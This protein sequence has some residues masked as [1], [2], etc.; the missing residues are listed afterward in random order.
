WHLRNDD[1]FILR[2]GDP[3]FVRETV[4]NMGGPDTAGFVEGSELDIPGVDRIHT[5]AAA[6]HLDWQYKFQKHWFRFMLWGRLGANPDEPESAWREE[7]TR[8]FG[9]AGPDAYEAIHQASKIL[10]LVTSY[11]WNY[12]NGDWYPEGSVGS[13]NTSYEQPRV[14][15]RRAAMYHDI[16]TYIF[17]NTIEPSLMNIPE[18]V[19]GKKTGSTPLEVADRLEGYGR[20]ALE[21][22]GRARA[23]VERGQKEFACT[24][25]DVQAAG[26]LGLY[27]AAKLRGAVQLARVLLLGETKARAEAVRH[28]EQALA[29]WRNVVKATE[30]HYVT[31]EV[32]LFGQFDWKRYTPDVERDVEIARRATPFRRDGR[33]NTYALEG[34]REWLEYASGLLGGPAAPAAKASKPVVIEAESAASVTPAMQ[35]AAGYISLAPAVEQRAGESIT[36][37]RDYV[38]NANSATWRF[39]L[40]E[41]GA[42][43]MWA[44]CWW[45]E[46]GAGFTVL[47]DE[48]NGRVPALR[49]GAKDPLASWALTKLDRVFHLGAGP[50]TLRLYGR[51]P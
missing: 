9:R 51:Q 50:H 21:L 31:H 36:G 7:F 48:S 23:G 26:N 14:N 11:H 20:R 45:P 25:L 44:L 8:R 29:A 30:P 27:H 41:D 13:W 17:N 35:T 12:M 24:E 1:L 4:K 33:I 28:L 22:I 47:M 10:P 39:A 16:F 42:Y 46:R 43:E 38:V 6:A 18:F 3:D 15:Y 49:A 19:A 34:M 2:W 32:W 37:A 40:A 5:A